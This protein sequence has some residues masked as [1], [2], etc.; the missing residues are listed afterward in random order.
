MTT[1]HS[2]GSLYVD[3]RI[4]DSK[5][6]SDLLKAR[7]FIERTN[8][9]KIELDTAGAKTGLDRVRADIKA[10]QDLSAR[11]AQT[12]QQAARI[13]GSEYRAQAESIRVV[14]GE[15]NKAAAAA[16][17]QS[18][19]ARLSAQLA[20]QSARE[21]AAAIRAAAAA[22][23]EA[24]RA[25]R[26]EQAAANAAQ[27][28]GIQRLRERAATEVLN[29]RLRRE[30]EV[31]AS[32]AARE[33]LLQ[34][35]QRQQA[36]RDVVQGLDNEQRAMRNLWQAGRVV[37]PELVTGQQNIQTRALAAAA[38]LDRESDA[39]R[40]LTQVAAAAQRSIDS[41]SGRSTPGGLS[42][43]VLTGIQNSGLFSQIA[44][45][46]GLGNAAMNLG[47]VAGAFGTARAAAAGFAGTTNTAATAVGF[48]S[49]GLA[50]VAVALG[51]AVIAF[52]ALGR[53][54]LQEIQ[55]TQTGL[56]ILQANGVEDLGAIE[57][58]VKSLQKA[59]G[60]VG[61]SFARSDLTLALADTVKAGVSASDALTLMQSSARLAA[62]EQINLNDATTLLLKNIRQYGMSVEDAAKVG[63]MLAK[64]GNLAAGTANDLSVGLGIVAG[65]GK[66]AGIE[67]YDLLGMLV[68]LDNKGMNAADVGA[69]GLRAAIAALGDPSKKAMGILK[70]L[71]IEINDV[72]GKARPA[73]DIMI[74]LGKKMAGMG[75]VADKTTG[76][77]SGNGEALRTVS[78][79]MDN[80]AAAAVINLTGEWQMLGQEVRRSD[81]ELVNYSNTMQQGVEPAL[82]SL[83]NA[84][85]DSGGAFA[86]SFAGP[87]AGFL[88]DTL[89]PMV[90]K[91][92]EMLE[93]IAA[94]KST[95]EVNLAVKFTP[96]D[97][98]TE[99][100][101]KVLGLPFAA[102]ASVA[103]VGNVAMLS[104]ALVRGGVLKESTNPKEA[105]AQMKEVSDNYEFYLKKAIEL[106]AEFVA[107]MEA[108][109]AK[110]G[111]QLLPPA[112]PTGPNVLNGAGP[113]LPG[114]QRATQEQA[115]AFAYGV[116]QNLGE[117]FKRD[118]RV[119]SDCA[120]IAYEILKNIGAKIKGTAVENA[121]VPT[122]EKNAKDSG[123]TQVKNMADVKPGDLVIFK[124]GGINPN[125][126]GMHAEVA[127]GYKNGQLMLTGN[128]GTLADGRTD[129]ITRTRA[130]G[131]DAKYA[132]YYRAP[133]SPYATGAIP[134]GINTSATAKAASTKK[135]G[136]ALLTEA[137]RILAAIDKADKAKDVDGGAIA[138]RVLKAFEASGDRPARAL[139][140]VRDELGKTNKTVSQFGK[141]YDGLKDKMGNSESYFKLS[142]DAAA[143]ASTLEDISKNAQKAAKSEKDKA[144]SDALLALAGDAASK[145]RQQR[146][147]IQREKD[148]KPELTP[149][150][151][152]QAGEVRRLAALAQEKALRARTTGQLSDIIKGGVQ[153]EGDSGRIAGAEAELKRR[154]DL[155]TEAGKQ[156][157][158][159]LEDNAALIGKLAEETAK[160]AVARDK[161]Q[162]A[163]RAKYA[164]E[165][166]NLDVQ[167]ASATLTRTQELNRQELADF[168]GTAAQKVT[169]LKR[170]AKDEFNATEQAAR[171]TRDKAVREAENDI[172]NPN[173]Q[174]NIDGANQAYKDAVSKAQNIQ[175]NAG[176]QA[177]EDQ[178]KAI[179]T[180]RD[181]YSK[182]AQT[183]REKIAAG[184]VE[185][186]DLTDYRVGMDQ[187]TV[188]AEKGGL[189]QT[190]YIKGARQSAEALYQA[191]IDAQI[192]AGM[193]AD[194]GDGQSR[195]AEAGKS[196]AVSLEDAIA[197]MPGTLEGNAEYLKLLQ[198]MAK[199]GQVAGG[200]VA[201]ISDLMRD[202]A[203]DAE[204]A[205]GA[206]AD[207][208]DSYDRAA[209]A[210]GK[211]VA[212]QQDAI[213]QIPGSTEANAAYLKVLQDLEDA[214]KLAA[215][216]VAAVSQA[217]R[218]QQTAADTTAAQMERLTTQAGKTA[219]QYI[220][221]GDTE[222]AMRTL[223]TALDAAMD[224]AMRGED[225]ADAIAALIDRI[226]ELAG[227][228]GLSDGFNAFVS[229]LGGTIE[230]QIS[231]VVDQIER[232]TDPAM[233]GKLKTFLADLRAGVSGYEDPSKAGYTP[234]SNGGGFTNGQPGGAVTA[235]AIASARDLTGALK[236]G[237]KDNG[238]GGVELDLPSLQAS[239]SQATD[240]LASEVGQALPEATR[241][242]LQDGIADAQ[243]F[244]DLAS[245][246]GDAVQDGVSRTLNVPAA[247]DNEFTKWADTIF[248]LGSEGLSDPTTLNALTESLDTARKA[249]R[250]TEDDL[251]NLLNLIRE[252]GTEPDIKL[253][254]KLDLKD[255][256]D[257][258]KQLTE[259]FDSGKITAPEFVQGLQQAGTELEGFA[260][261]AREA[262]NPVLARQFDELAASLRAMSPAIAKALQAIGKFQEYAG[263]VQ[264]LAGAFAALDDGTSG[265]DI[266]ANI[267]GIGNAAGK[268]VDLAG[269]VSKIL[270]NPADI[271]AWVGAITK[272]A[273]SVADAIAGFKKA[274][275]E[276]KK[277]KEDFQ[278]DN[279]LLNGADYQKTFTRSR[280]FFADVF[281][282]GPEVVNQIDELG[283]NFAKTMQSAFTDGIK[284]GLKDAI[285][286][287]D[288]SKFKDKLHET[289]FDGMLGGT[290]DLFL[291]EELLKNII[292]PAIKAWSDALKTPD[293][294]DDAAALA[295][296]DSAINQVDGLASKFYNDVAPKFQAIAS[297]YGIGPQETRGVDTSNLSTLPEPIQFALATPLLEGVRGLKE[298]A[299]IFRGSAASLD[300]TFKRGLEVR[301]TGSAQ[302][303]GYVSTT[304]A[305]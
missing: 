169:L 180:A 232:V 186:S 225:A 132:T 237:F 171:A 165:R 208:A 162:K 14:T 298:A 9:I 230:E 248:G 234:G 93:K 47:I 250:L 57:E 244:V 287:N 123:F 61:G 266:I 68:E 78:G 173:K 101:L 231:A 79:I 89:T 145:A 166:R 167:E 115:G 227:T 121:W 65:T 207:V 91:L 8:G 67:M 95:G 103:Q 73:G 216:T 302:G 41:A 198:D 279:P 168:K 11:D 282:G 296:I 142:E 90:Q 275:A 228:T 15:Q 76:L 158:K 100:I 24:G 258:I 297:Q 109:Y 285:M 140:I 58:G 273:S 247:P 220:E 153:K 55:K 211:Y 138:E 274:Q 21:Q 107:K 1:G 154:A 215:G 191:G 280:G 118:P 277:L 254:E 242:G 74:D 239:I 33:A 203:I 2:V 224:A 201:H 131:S 159:A 164:A 177:L 52:A 110:S 147:A 104:D 304:G 112:Q 62:A 7:Q 295:G 126:S 229:G 299:D 82:T 222:G 152:E 157:R 249:G 44:G 144:K 20:G 133:D 213:D 98:A 151:Q 127:T 53:T 226:N 137:R 290:I 202:Q 233:L 256:Q 291:N 175:A 190:K 294:A 181:G 34:E 292:A 194:L 66:Q 218:D 22:Q 245:N 270:L 219:D 87:L 160:A 43:G 60:A 246:I 155:N 174:R 252:F 124:G 149:L 286:N 170:Q 96:G 289:V 204:I 223:Q 16:R 4:D 143:Y 269:D 36:I 255:M 32:V 114:Q 28:E 130:I 105:I 284:G 94:V 77:L 56:N 141:T 236:G 18:A 5:L 263:Y 300:E 301:V 212:T 197:A 13:L 30:L 276:V 72:N 185:L 17:A 102:G 117:I 206:Y 134:P 51:G 26:A 71:K 119:A 293:L 238:S 122:L 12:R 45:Q 48:L 39:Y 217:M 19:Q 92:G 49:A 253:S 257:G 179:Q 150:Q 259:D 196:Y 210:A 189:A 272:V 70:E 148:K 241:K 37:A 221:L 27:R 35:R 23:N 278:K 50:T 265:T 161:E 42:H 283:L 192:A 240:L 31:Q 129:G 40:R 63:D 29:A 205:A 10:L 97:S 214:G 193:F 209:R 54:G 268:L 25:A 139:K 264:Q 288:F 271:G 88:N 261:A 251:Q 106:D 120:I 281:G 83:K 184:K 267:T 108:N 6:Q 128:P 176:T 260:Q 235:G 187:A 182:L 195:A 111:G 125:G 199:A 183:M 59:L 116:I 135:S 303:T 81:G 188:A 178:S 156:A 305:L 163:L 75:I 262:G 84:W 200:T 64:A 146:E 243:A 113:L 86:K 38:A 85:K 172:T 3:L 46:A 99:R 136:E 69:N 80:R